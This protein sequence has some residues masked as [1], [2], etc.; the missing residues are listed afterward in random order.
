MSPTQA[1]I[2]LFSDDDARKD[3]TVGVTGGFTTM[4]V[5]FRIPTNTSQTYKNT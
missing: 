4:K 5:H 3:I 1:Y 2:S